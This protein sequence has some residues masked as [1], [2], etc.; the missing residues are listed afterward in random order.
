[1]ASSCPW[2]SNPLVLL[3]DEASAEGLPVAA[4]VRH[5]GVERAAAAPCTLCPYV[6]EGECLYP[7]THTFPPGSSPRLLSWAIGVAASPAVAAVAAARQLHARGVTGAPAHIAV[8]LSC[9]GEARLWE[10]RLALELAL[11]ELAQ[12]ASWTYQIEPAEHGQQ[13]VVVLCLWVG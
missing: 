12:H 1:M 8:A 4:A 6:W 3:F 9:P 7:Q 13:S 2:P 11:G 10:V 5:L